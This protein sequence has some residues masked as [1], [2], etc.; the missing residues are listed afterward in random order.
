MADSPERRAF[1]RLYEGGD[2]KVHYCIPVM[3]YETGEAELTNA[4]VELYNNGREVDLLFSIAKRK[5]INTSWLTP[6]AVEA[7]YAYVKEERT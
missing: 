7:D 1:A 3:D 4:E 2:M 5:N 6:G